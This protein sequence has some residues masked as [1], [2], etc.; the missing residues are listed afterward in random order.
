MERE[1]LGFSRRKIYDLELAKQLDR[2]MFKFQ[3]R[4]KIWI[5]WAEEFQRGGPV[6]KGHSDS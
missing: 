3:T 6:S 5:R 4:K 2:I 1:L